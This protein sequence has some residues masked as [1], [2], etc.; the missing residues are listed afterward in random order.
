MVASHVRDGWSGFT[1]QSANSLS[2]YLGVMK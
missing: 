1:D 2:D